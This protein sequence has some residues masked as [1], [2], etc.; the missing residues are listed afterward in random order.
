[1]AKIHENLHRWFVVNIVVS[2]N[3]RKDRARFVIAVSSCVM[4][5]PDSNIFDSLE[6]NDPKEVEEFKLQMKEQFNASMFANV[7]T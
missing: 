5:P 3:N 1:M 6:S 2:G 7:R 4:M